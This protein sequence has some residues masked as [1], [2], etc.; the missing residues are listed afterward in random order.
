MVFYFNKYLRIFLFLKFS[1]G[2]ML[3]VILTLKNIIKKNKHI[4][5][6][7]EIATASNNNHIFNNVG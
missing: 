7:C 1:K 5:Q 3:E 6:E 4:I 2:G